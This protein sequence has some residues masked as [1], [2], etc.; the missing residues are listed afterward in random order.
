MDGAVRC[1]GKNAVGQTGTGSAGAN[2]LVPTPVVDA[3]MQPLMG[4]EEV[5]QGIDS[6]C[7]RIGTDVWCWGDNSSGQLGDASPAAGHPYA[8]KVPGLPPI[9]QLGVAAYS[10]CALAADGGVWCWGLGSDGELANGMTATK[11]SPVLAFTACP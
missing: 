1:W 11:R 6:G 2:L 9:V 7:A 10:A 5:G 8:V 4:G 3:A